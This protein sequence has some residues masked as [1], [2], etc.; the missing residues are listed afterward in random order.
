GFSPMSF[1]LIGALIALAGVGILFYWPRDLTLL[2]PSY[3]GGGYFIW[4]WLREE[5]GLLKGLLDGLILFYGIIPTLQPASFGRV[6]ATYGV[7]SSS[8]PSSGGAV[9]DKKRSD[10]YELNGAAAVLIGGL[11]HI[12]YYKLITLSR[13]VETIL[14]MV[15]GDELLRATVVESRSF[16]TT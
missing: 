4:L 9:V 10:R 6:Y 12:L 1:D 8:P 14:L 13:V 11:G 15:R 3:L 16:D 7:G 2:I 5:E